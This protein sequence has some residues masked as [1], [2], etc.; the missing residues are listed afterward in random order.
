MTPKCVE[1]LVGTLEVENTA[2][3]ALMSLQPLS[4][5]RPELIKPHADTIIS[6]MQENQN[7]ASQG[8]GILVHLADS[9][10]GHWVTCAVSG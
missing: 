8:G 5:K 4:E 9:T 2:G 1:H 6:H 3:I 10:V 7:M